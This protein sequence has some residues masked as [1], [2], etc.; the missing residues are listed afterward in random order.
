MAS[1]SAG[2]DPHRAIQ[3]TTAAK[4]ASHAS[5]SADTTLALAAFLN[6]STAAVQ[7]ISRARSVWS[8]TLHQADSAFYRCVT[9]LGTY[10]PETR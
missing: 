7:K 6:L 9:E 4:V 1:T 8:R 2:N 3:D 5:L 10:D